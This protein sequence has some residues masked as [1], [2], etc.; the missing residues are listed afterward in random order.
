MSD[1]NSLNN[2]KQVYFVGIGGIG[3]SAITRFFNLKGLLVAG[4]DKT[5]S[6]VTDALIDEG[7]KIVFSDD[8]ALINDEFKNAD[9]T[10]VVYTPAIDASHRQL[11][12]FR[13]NKFRVLKRSQILGLITETYNA[14]CVAGTHGK[15][16]ISTMAAHLYKQSSVGCVAFL[17]GISKNYKTNFL[18]DENSQFVVVEADEFDRSFLTLTPQSALVSSVDADHLDIYEN[19]D[20]LTTAFR[21]FAERIVPNGIFIVKNNLP[22]KW[23]LNENVKKLTYSLNGI[24]DYFAT[25]IKQDGDSYMFNLV[26]PEGI[27]NDLKMGISGLLNVENAIGACALAL[28]NGVTEDEIRE[29]L[30][31]FTGIARRF[32]IHINTP[33]LVYIDDYAHHPEEIRATLKSVRAMYPQHHI[34]GI[35]QPHLFT[36]TRDFYKEFAET[37]S[38]T[39]ELILLDIYPAREKPIEGVSSQMI[40]NLIDN[41][42]VHYYPKEELHNHIPVKKPQ[43]IITMGAGDIDRE[44]LLIKEKLVEL[45]N[46]DDSKKF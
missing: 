4:Y 20:N 3:M 40:G 35:F 13:E 18:W 14:I 42:P 37:L 36:R 10:L 12:F 31:S 45:L 1:N 29:S 21:M 46:N 19:K 34:L 6:S 41:I 25:N 16:T 43:V 24:S 28:N 39:D 26:T 33:D 30:P 11:I 32:D 2:I 44:V 7:I 8:A 27:I 22:V 17:G 9:T 23:Q 5:P 38:M 15:T